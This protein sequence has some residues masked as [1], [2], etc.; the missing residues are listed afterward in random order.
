MND[1]LLL[2][3]ILCSSLVPG[4]IIFALPERSHRL[5][6]TLNMAG[7]LLKLSLVALLF[8]LVYQGRFPELR[9][10]LLPGMEL[11]LHADSLSLLFLGLSAWAAPSIPGL[12]H[13]YNRRVH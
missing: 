7:A 8:I 13:R 12:A 9:I 3:A 1:S 10:A 2:L 5:R 4:L 6:T 11:A